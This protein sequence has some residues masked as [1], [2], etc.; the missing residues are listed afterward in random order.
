MVCVLIA[1]LICRFWWV[2]DDFVCCGFNLVSFAWIRSFACFMWLFG[3]FVLVCVLAVGF[4]LVLTW[5]FG[6]VDG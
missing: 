6:W 5:Y 3:V 1:G 4:V 2:V